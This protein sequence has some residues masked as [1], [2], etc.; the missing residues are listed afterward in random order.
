MFVSHFNDRTLF[1]LIIGKFILCNYAIA[2]ITIGIG[3][4]F[5]P[6]AKLAGSVGLSTITGFVAATVGTVGC[7]SGRG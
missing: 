2:L 4:V 7:I 1:N 3:L 5:F 6:T